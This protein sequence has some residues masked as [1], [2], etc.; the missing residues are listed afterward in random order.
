M[1]TI[2][3]KLRT[4]ISVWQ[5]RPV[6]GVPTSVLRRDLST[7]VLVVGAGV[8]SGALMAEALAADGHS[9]AIVDR[10][11]PFQ[12]STAASTAL[13]QYQIDVPL[14]LLAG[15]LGDVDAIRA[16]RRSHQAVQGGGG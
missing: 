3:R 2:K 10:R 7:D 13:V 1:T 15:K 12:G 14:I 16:W 5:G 6:R 9:V 11:G 8:V 4:G